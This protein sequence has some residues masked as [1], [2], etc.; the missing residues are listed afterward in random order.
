MNAQ[1]IAYENQIWFVSEEE[2]I[3]AGYLPDD[4]CIDITDQDIFDLWWRAKFRHL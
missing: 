4:D 3:A 2:V 1:N